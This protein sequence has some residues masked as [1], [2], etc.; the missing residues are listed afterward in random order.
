[1]SALFK[2]GD[3]VI[4]KS[5]HEMG[6]QYGFYQNSVGFYDHGLINVPF[7]FTKDMESLIGFKYVI[8]AIVDTNQP[9]DEK[10]V[11]PNIRLCLKADDY[12]KYPHIIKYSISAAMLKLV[13][14]KDAIFLYCID[15][16]QE[17]LK[18][19]I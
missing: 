8:R 10:I 19:I 1:M 14:R 18:D 17:K 6:E 4:F 16:E 3:T 7:L 11:E 12:L 9:G 5:W 15:F 13:N 2:I